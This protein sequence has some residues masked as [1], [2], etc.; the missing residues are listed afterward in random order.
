MP[1]GCASATALTPTTPFRRCKTSVPT[2]HEPFEAQDAA[3]GRLHG[4]L[5]AEE[6][7][8]MPTLRA[9]STRLAD[10]PEPGSTMTFVHPTTQEMLAA[11]PQKLSS[12]NMLLRIGMFHILYGFLLDGGV[13]RSEVNANGAIM[14]DR[15]Q[16]V[17]RSCPHCGVAA[18]LMPKEA[19]FEIYVCP[20]CG[21]YRI[22]GINQKLI[23]NGVVDPKAFQIYQHKDGNRW[24]QS[25]RQ[26]RQDGG[27]IGRAPRDHPQ[28]ADRPDGEADAMG[29]PAD[30]ESVLIAI[31]RRHGSPR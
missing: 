11:M 25:P 23:A 28:I 13:G 20:H 27:A 15:T 22:S 24:L 17:S 26:N 18:K 16:P 2:A 4:A 19:H 1:N 10:I 31:E 14:E 6:P 5:F 30:P 29:E 3:R 21:H 12:S 9:L 7:H 8:G